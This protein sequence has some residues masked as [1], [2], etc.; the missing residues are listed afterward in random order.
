ME[1]GPIRKRGGVNQHEGP[2][3]RR[4]KHQIKDTA[5]YTYGHKNRPKSVNNFDNDPMELWEWD[6]TRWIEIIK[7][8]N[9]V[10]QIRHQVR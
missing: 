3:K 8:A 5:P 4:K 10:T 9:S 6:G 1:N 7:N 2:A